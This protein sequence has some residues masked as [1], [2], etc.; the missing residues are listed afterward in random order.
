LYAQ[1]KGLI[2]GIFNPEVPLNSYQVSANEVEA[3]E[4]V[5][6]EGR[7]VIKEFYDKNP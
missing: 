4:I 5:T 7:E 3:I 1:T 2:K 6:R